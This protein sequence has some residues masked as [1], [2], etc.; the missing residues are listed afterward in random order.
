MSEKHPIMPSVKIVL[1]TPCKEMRGE[2]RERE[3]ELVF[4]FNAQAIFEEITGVSVLSLFGKKGNLLNSSRYTRAFLFCQLLSQD[5]NVQ[6]DEF[7]RIVSP[8]ELSI[9]QIG[10]MITPKNLTEVTTKTRQALINFFKEP[11]PE[12]EPKEN[13]PSR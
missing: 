6:F 9:I 10:K 13:P 12:E 4:D 5:E 1:R 2:M 3:F 8:P 11:A 7:G